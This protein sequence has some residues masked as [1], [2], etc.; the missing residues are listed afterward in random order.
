M[1]K[2]VSK[3]SLFMLSAFGVMAA[4]AEE[5]R[6]QYFE[7]IPTSENIIKGDPIKVYYFFNTNCPSCKAVSPLVDE[8]EQ[9]MDKAIDLESI[10]HAPFE[11]WKW[12]SKAYLAAKEFNPHLTRKDVENAQ[13]RTKLLGVTD[14]LKAADVVTFATSSNRGKIMTTLSSVKMNDALQSIEAV[15]EKYGVHGTPSIV[16]IGDREAYRVSPEF[17]LTKEGVIKVSEALVAYQHSKPTSE[18]SQN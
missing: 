17:G 8:W 11:D 13:E 3:I 5:V 10:P 1:N 2:V 16:I 14:I 7:T 4:N 12:A 9:K 15:A 18:R 6:Q